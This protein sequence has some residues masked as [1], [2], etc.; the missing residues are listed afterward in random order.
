MKRMRSADMLVA[1][2]ELAKVE[3]RTANP[4]LT[5]ADML[6][7]ERT[8]QTVVAMQVAGVIPEARSMGR[9]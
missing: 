8:V 5:F 6:R 9:G 4:E 1:V 3:Q 7:L 2:Y